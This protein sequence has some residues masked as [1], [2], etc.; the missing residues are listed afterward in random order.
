MPSDPGEDFRVVSDALRA[1]D[2]DRAM[3][4]ANQALT[5]GIE[6]P[7][8]LNLRALRLEREQRYAEALV[9]LQRAYALA[10]R[11]INTL[12]ALGL[13]FANLER[14]AEAIAAYDAGIAIKPDFAPLHF[15]RA[16]AFEMQGDLDQARASYERAQ[17]LAPQDVTAT[18]QLAALAARRGDWTA[19][20]TLGETAL[21]R[22]PRSP[23]A[24]LA[25]AGAERTAGDLAA[26]ESRVRALLDQD[27]LGP[28]DGALAWGLLGDVLDSAGRAA[29]AFDAF[30][31]ANTL[32]LDHYRPRYAA[33]GTVPATLSWLNA[34]F[35]RATAD[36]WKP[37]TTAA[38]HAPV[39][40]HVFLVGFPRSGTTLLERVLASAGEVATLEEKDTLADTVRE[41]MDKPSSL[42]RLRDMQDWNLESYRRAYWQRVTAYTGDLSGRLLV[43]KLPLNTMKLPL[44]ARLF[45]NARILFALRDPRD[46]VLS[47]FR[48]RFRMNASMYELLTLPRAARLYDGVMTLAQSL[49]EVLPLAM[50]THRYEDLVSDFDGQM[51]A[52]CDFVGLPWRDEMRDFARGDGRSIATPSS[53]QVARGLYTEGV[54]QWRRYA[55]EMAP[56]MKTLAPWVAEFGYDAA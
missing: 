20:R 32:L 50:H 45:P 38:P 47:C 4:L 1:Q 44:I 9:D 13:C 36:E 54:G 28:I 51:Q 40:Q 11:D 53:A 12:N 7:L 27:G 5:R 18:S 26:A 35:A 41:F 24:A 29:E 52:I 6:H 56:V 49:R 21:A 22:N 17:G 15:N 55:E 46:V 42:D 3:A 23:P 34:Y 16:W 43:D 33:G 30:T 39:R 19:A 8:F 2:L 31:A 14:P 25:I 48:Q 37:K 10:P